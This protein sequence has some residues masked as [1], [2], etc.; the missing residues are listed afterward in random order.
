MAPDLAGSGAA[1]GA[2]LH[3]LL[4]FVVLLLLPGLL[5]VRAPWPAVPFLSLSFWALSLGWL[6]GA[7]RQRFLHAALAGFL[8]LALLRLLKPLDLRAPRV[9]TLLVLAAAAL[10]LSAFFCWPLCP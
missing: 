5:V 3:G 10:P 9:P 7:T 1:L 2:S 8:L 6:F 4:A